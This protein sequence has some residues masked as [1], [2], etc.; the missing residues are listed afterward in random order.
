[1]NT[2]DALMDAQ[3]NADRAALI[4]DYFFTN[5]IILNIDTT[6]QDFMLVTPFCVTGP[7]VLKFELSANISTAVNMAMIMLIIDGNIVA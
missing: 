5:D 2:V 7:S 4:E 1:M 3:E 6:D